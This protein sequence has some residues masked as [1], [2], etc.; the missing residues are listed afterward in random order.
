MKKKPIMGCVRKH[1]VQQWY[2]HTTIYSAVQ[3]L[4]KL[5]THIYIYTYTEYEAAFVY[6]TGDC[7]SQHIGRHP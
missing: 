6:V 5:H 4:Y 3:E 7:F 1:V 2:K